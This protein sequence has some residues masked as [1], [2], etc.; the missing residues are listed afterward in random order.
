[1]IIDRDRFDTDIKN[2]KAWARAAEA[3]AKDYRA[4]AEA[5]VEQARLE[6]SQAEHYRHVILALETYLNGQR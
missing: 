5:M 6:E 2:N 3:N 1:M 4:Q